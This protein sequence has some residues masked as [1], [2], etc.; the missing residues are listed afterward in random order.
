MSE[1]EVI[2]QLIERII[3]LENRI[4]RLELGNQQITEPIGVSIVKYPTGEHIKGNHIN[5]HREN[6]PPDGRA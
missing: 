3:N 5:F 6:H 4:V 2:Q 1:R